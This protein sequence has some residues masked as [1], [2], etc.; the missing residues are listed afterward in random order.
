MNEV[1]KLRPCPISFAGPGAPHTGPPYYDDIR[2]G[3]DVVGL[4]LPDNRRV[5]DRSRRNSMAIRASVR[6]SAS[7]HTTT[8]TVAQERLASA[9]CRVR[10]RRRRG[11]VT[12]LSQQDH[13]ATLPSYQ[14]ARA[15]FAAKKLV[16]LDAD[17]HAKHF[18]Q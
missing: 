12:A 1:V 10:S 11:R 2:R 16:N 14:P 13:C 5:R 8:R 7:A 3:C 18:K 9:H 17:H 6:T 15:G 4:S